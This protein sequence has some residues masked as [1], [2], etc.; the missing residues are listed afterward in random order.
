MICRQCNVEKP[1]S[2]FIN[3]GSADG[4]LC[5]KCIYENKLKKDELK[6][7]VKPKREC[8]LCG[9]EAKGRRWKFCS[10]ECADEGNKINMKDNWRH[11]INAP[12]VDWRKL[13]L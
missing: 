13:K 12:T 8:I 11:K 7:A 4:T 10:E 1:P 3:V 5:S 6:P 9:K 2:Q